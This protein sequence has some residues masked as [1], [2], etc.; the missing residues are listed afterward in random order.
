SRSPMKIIQAKLFRQLR[1]NDPTGAGKNYEKGVSMSFRGLSKFFIAAALAVTFVAFAGVAGG[2]EAKAQ[3][4]YRNH[5]NRR[6]PSIRYR[7]RER[8]NWYRYNNRRFY[9]YRRYPNYR[10]YGRSYYRP[11][12]PYYRGR[13]W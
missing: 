2:S 10:Y 3:G 11:Y 7:Q 4:I 6:G 9:G 13:R 1:S 8:Y 12:R 5:W